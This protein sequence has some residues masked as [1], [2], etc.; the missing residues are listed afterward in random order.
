MTKE[1]AEKVVETALKTTKL[2]REYT[3]LAK[4]LE[5]EI[6]VTTC[7]T[8]VINNHCDKFFF[9]YASDIRELAKIYGTAV[10]KDKRETY[11]H[12]NG[13]K[14]FALNN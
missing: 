6:G 2:A 1:Q 14:F 7:E 13:I 12:I 8:V 5:E 10:V 9:L 4:A 3:E 11:T